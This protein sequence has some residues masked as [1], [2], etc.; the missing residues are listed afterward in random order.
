MTC[1]GPTETL[2]SH[3]RTR[4]SAVIRAVRWANPASEKRSLK[5][6]HVSGTLGIADS[7]SRRIPR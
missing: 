4:L 5:R 6:F 3:N 2:D 1:F 7:C